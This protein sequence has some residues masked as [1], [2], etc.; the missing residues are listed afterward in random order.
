MLCNIGGF[1][2]IFNS[3]QGRKQNQQTQQQ[4]LPKVTGKEKAQ[5]IT[6]KSTNKANNNNKPALGHDDLKIKLV[7]AKRTV[8]KAQ[9]KKKSPLGE[10]DLR[11]KLNQ[12]QETRLKSSKA[13]QAPAN[14]SLLT[15]SKA[16]RA[17][18]T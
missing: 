17:K 8:Q 6:S 4:N 5:T 3:R 16:G 13:E 1:P 9:N 2:V 10:T 18:G 12:K 15:K 14:K 7:G 11:N